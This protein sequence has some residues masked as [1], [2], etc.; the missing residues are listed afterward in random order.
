MLIIRK[1]TRKKPEIE[2][3][4]IKN[5]KKIYY[6]TLREEKGR[7]RPHRFRS[8]DEVYQP[9]RAVQMLKAEP[10][11]LSRDEETLAIKKELEE[12]F[13]YLQTPYEWIDLCRHCFMEG[14]VTQNP[15]YVFHGE[16][17]CRSCALHEVKK[18]LKFRKVSVPVEPILDRLKNVDQIITLLDPRYSTAKDTLYDVIKGEMPENLLSVDD[19]EI[20]ERL[21]AIFKKEVRTLLPIQQKAV[22]AGLLNNQN[23]L[24]VSAT[25]SGKT[26][27][28]ELAGLKKVCEGKKLLFLVPL[29]ALA[30][31]KYEDFK[32]R[33]SSLCSVSIRV[34][35][36][37]IH[38]AEDLLVMDSDVNADIIVGTYEGLDFL[39]RANVGLGDVG[40]IVIDEVHMVSDPERGPRLDGMISRLRALYPEAQFL[41]LS[42]TVGNPEEIS[43]DLKCRLVLYTE[44]PVPLERHIVLTPDKNDTIKELIEKE[45][46]EVS[47]YGYHGQSIL[48]TNS[49]RNCETL[50]GF[51]RSKGIRAQAYHAGLP[52]VKRKSTETS[53]WN[54]KLQAVCCTAALSAGVDFPSSCVIFDSYKMGIEPLRKQEFEQM[55]GRAGRPLYHEKGKVY[56]LVEPFSEEDTVLH[57]LLEGEMEDVDMVYTEEQELENALAARACG[58]SLEAVNR[59]ALWELRPSLAGE[60]EKYGMVTDESITGYGRAVSVS[61]LNVE[62]AEFIRRNL[63]KDILDIVIPLELFENVYLTQRLKSQLNLEVD[64]LFSGACLEVLGRSEVGLTILKAFFVCDCRENPYCEHSKWNI[65]RYICELRV[66]GLSPSGISKR[67][68]QD[69]GLLLYPGDVFSYLDAIVHKLEAVER[70]AEVFKEGRTV[71]KARILKNQIE[72]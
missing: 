43:R 58:L 14:R 4:S 21:K 40:C 8:G 54:Q 47:R 51:L 66:K 34:G 62:Q 11:Y 68:R 72:R 5:G 52:Y 32:K 16:K 6:L 19:L 41:G 12:L 53:F 39:I 29:V 23:L 64:T 63:R 48:F 45:W 60:L 33:Y 56:L 67:F 22:E 55:T 20:P 30:N 1:T 9:K 71:T 59:Y 49:R 69:Y 13:S 24:V 27:I 26:L 10:V 61:F 37:R 2:I 65:S 17:I 15:E 25:A 38:T 50:A 57:H 42:A 44:R 35:M 3:Y 36:S 28:A 7:I 31:Q 18:E 46:K 70:I